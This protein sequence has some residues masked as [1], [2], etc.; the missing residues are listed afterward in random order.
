[1]RR[2]FP[3]KVKLA[4]WE[5]AKGHCEY[6]GAKIIGGQAHYDHAVPDAIGGDPTFDNCRVACRTCHGLK[7]SKT[8]VPMIAKG[9]RVR[10]KH[11]NAGSTKRGGG[12]RGWKKFSGEI[13]WRKDDDE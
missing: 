1:M 13:V 9:K 5:H 2:E 6:C 12:F 10:S 4:R 7:T 11:V 3:A 8:D